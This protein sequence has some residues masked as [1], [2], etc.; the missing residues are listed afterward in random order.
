MKNIVMGV[1]AHVDAGKTTLSEAILY[2]TGVIRTM[3]RV[4]DKNTV[5]D[6]NSFERARGITIF[7]KQACFDTDNTHVTLLDTPGHVDFSAEMER[8]LQVLDYAVLVISGTDGVQGHTRTLWRLLK[9]YNIPCI[10]FVNKMDQPDNDK[11]VIIDSLKHELSDSIIDFSDISSKIHEDIAVASGDEEVLNTYLEK[12]E[13]CDGD[14]SKLIKERTIYPC[15]FGSA[16]KM[17]GIEKLL[18]VLD[19]F[20]VETAFGDVFSA[21]VYKISRDTDGGRL[22]HMRVTGGCLKVRD[23]IDDEK[24]TQIRVYSGDKYECPESVGAGIVCAVKGLEHTVAGQGLGADT[25]NSMKLME[26]VISYRLIVPDTVSQRAIYPD[27]R[28]LEEELPELSVGW[29]ERTEE[30]S[31]KIMGQ[32]QLEIVT[33]LIQERLGFTPSFDKGTITYKETIASTVIGVG[34]FEPLRHYAEVHL[35]LE[36]GETGSGIVVETDCSEDILDKNWQRLI[37]THIRE[38]SH[39]GVLTGSNI[40]DIKITLVNGRAHQKHTEGG[41]FRQATYRAI[42][43]GLMMAECVLLEPYYNFTIEIPSDMVGRVMTDMDTMHAKISVPEINGDKA[44][45]NGYGPVYTMRDYQINLN[46]YTHGLGSMMVS[47]GGYDRCHNQDEV[48]K[49]K[50]YNPDE[51]ISNPSSS[52]FCA[53]GVGFVVPWYEVYDYM[54]VTDEAYTSD[55]PEYRPENIRNREF[56]Y[57]I[58]LEEID[59]ILNRTFSANVRQDKHNHYKKKNTVIESYRNVKTYSSSR[60]KLLMVDGYN[61]IFAWDSLSELAKDNI[62][63]AKDRLVH[64]LSNYQG[65]TGLDI[66][67]IFDGYKVKSNPGSDCVIDNI[68]VIHTKENETADAF[69]EH[70]THMNVEKYAITVVTSDGMIQRIVRGANARIISSREF[71]GIMSE[72]FSKLREEYNL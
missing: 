33:G 8:T 45:I 53:H 71:A 17:Q 37:V 56:D 67:L 65:I 58:D 47:F 31:I 40:T 48:I 15:V 69:I 1:L 57:S 46:A 22:T 14:I 3:G 32:V 44:F 24:I 18:H 66:M 49:E 35:K 64:L 38:K 68:R 28:K 6:S 43:Q 2:K 41:D 54:H 12:G 19:T 51:D 25:G 63:S 50:G 27:I 70:F 60:K 62:D 61:V 10:I 20:T 36:A 16:L 42:R 72:E 23:I 4:D 21:R 59:E 5:L 34:H 39:K 13:V 55:V 52:V 29:D 7:S 9:Q 30:I 11:D 26:P